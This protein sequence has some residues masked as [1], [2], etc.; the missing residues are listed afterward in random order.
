MVENGPPREAVASHAPWAQSL[1]ATRCVALSH[2]PNSPR[3]GSNPA[4][5]PATKKTPHDG[6]PFAM[7][8]NR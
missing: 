5:R 2:G 8:E 1:A 6:A 3:R 7:A 4:I